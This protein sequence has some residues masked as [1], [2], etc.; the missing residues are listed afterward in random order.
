MTQLLRLALQQLDGACSELLDLPGAP[1]AQLTQLSA[2]GD[3]D[4][5]LLAVRTRADWLERVA[6]SR[7]RVA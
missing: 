2:R 3:L 6:A 7:F 5:T 4:G 1:V